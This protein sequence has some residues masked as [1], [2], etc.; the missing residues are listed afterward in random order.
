MSL[1]LHRDQWLALAGLLGVAVLCWYYLFRLASDMTVMTRPLTAIHPVSFQDLWLL[2]SMW[3]V[4]MA[5]MML[6]SAIPMILLYTRV[7]TKATKQGIALAS[8]TVFTLGY[9][10]VWTLFSLLATG[11]QWGLAELAL[12]SPAM[13]INSPALGAGLLIAA[14]LYQ[15][16]PWKDRC[17]EHCRNP[18]EFLSR[19]W[20]RGATGTLAMG[21]IHGVYCLG[22]CWLL[23]ALL[24][25]GGVMNLLWVALIAAFVLLEKT[26]PLGTRAGLY[27]GAGMIAVGILVL[28]ANVA[29]LS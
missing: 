24:F 27:T 19:H 10:L 16:T 25:V 2:F 7:A 20:R 14:G 4:M 18:A 5:G 1:P 28:L 15:A 3:A 9:V 8:T 29:P 17:L 22:C 11:V 23:M 6:P 12:L 13:V 26:T 21:M